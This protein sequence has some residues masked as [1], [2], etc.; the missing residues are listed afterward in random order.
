[1]I[2]GRPSPKV[3][4]Y[5]NDKPISS[6]SVAPF[7]SVSKTGHYSS[8]KSHSPNMNIHVEQIELGPLSRFYQ[9]ARLTCRAS[10]SLKVNPVSKTITLEITLP[11]MKTKIVQSETE[12]VAGEMSETRCRTFGSRPA[13]YI[14][15]WKD[16]ER[17]PDSSNTIFEGDN[18]TTSTLRT[19]FSVRDHGKI[20][21]CRAVNRQLDASAVEDFLRLD[22][23]FAPVVSLRPGPTLNVD[24]I[25]EGDDVYFECSIHS[26]PKILRL[27][28]KHENQSLVYNA[29]SGIIMSNQSLV[30][31]G[32]TRNHSG[33]YKCIGVNSHG[34]GISNSVQLTV[35]FSPV[36]QQP[37]RNI[38]GAGRSQSLTLS[39]PI[40]SLPYPLKFRW[41]LNSTRGWR[42]IAST[43][44]IQSE[45]LAKTTSTTDSVTLRIQ[46]EMEADF[47]T[48]ACWA[49]NDVGWQQDPCLFRF[50][51]AG[52]PES[53]SNCSLLNQ[54]ADSLHVSCHSNDDGG[55][56]QT[57]QLQV[58]DV[59]LQ[60][61]L[62]TL[63]SNKPEFYLSNLEAG[64]TFMLY[65]YAMNTKGSSH[66]VILPVS[67]LKEAAKRT[68]P[69]TTDNL[70]GS[71][72][73]AV[74]M[75]AG[76]AISLIAIITVAACIRY[77]RRNTALINESIRVPIK[78]N[79]SD[80]GAFSKDSVKITQ[81]SDNELS[82]VHRRQESLDDTDSG[83]Y[84]QPVRNGLLSSM[85]AADRSSCILRISSE[86]LANISDVPESS[87]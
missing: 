60:Q 15:W 2:G 47:G 53:L 4:W 18:V 73:I 3:A 36:C 21:T 44:L 76:V 85:A 71:V 25:K 10:N 30:L 46:P 65:L 83:F 14:T 87:V 26:N 40:Q 19:N 34:T 77:R 41:A 78:S 68:V 82:G 45:D 67:T 51:P 62:V 86:Y 17:L 61:P 74:A 75:G 6:T 7:F 33:N 57:F 42:D 12:Y 84:H 72:V 69:P 49:F 32:L 13:A 31:R 52:P 22:I 11:P 27:S 28:W 5:L 39:C 50:F 66:P 56:D 59:S 43:G 55:L 79:A 20:L 81:V 16:N 48:V 38:R 58:M 8:A 1:V 35:R 70:D 64:S 23:Q 29:S 24:L 9:D 54:S 80:V 37:I 63:Q